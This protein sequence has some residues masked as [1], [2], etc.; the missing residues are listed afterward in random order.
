MIADNSDQSNKSIE[1]L[2][3]YSLDESQ[4]GLDV[5]MENVKNCATAFG[6]HNTWREG[7]RKLGA[8][9]ETL[10]DFDVFEYSLC[11]IFNV[12]RRQYGDAKGNLESAASEFRATLV[13]LN[14]ELEQRNFK[15]LSDLLGNDLAGS[16]A[17]FKELMPL[18][19]MELLKQS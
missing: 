14:T 2:T 4:A 15:K 8:L 1:E 5:L 19:K 12:D 3:I 17:R 13:A 11:S 18:L 6:D 16:L 7:I 10:H 9:V